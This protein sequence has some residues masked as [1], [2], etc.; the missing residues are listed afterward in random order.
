MEAQ[1]VSSVWVRREGRRKTFIGRGEIFDA[2]ER[3][4]FEGLRTGMLRPA[5]DADLELPG[6]NA[7]AVDHRATQ[8]DGTPLD[9]VTVGATTAAEVPPEP[10]GHKEADAQAAELGIQF[11]K[12]TTLPDKVQAIRQVR[13][14]QAAATDTP[15]APDAGTDVDLSTLPDGELI[16]LGIDHGHTEEE[17]VELS[18]DELVL[19]VAE[20]VN[21]RTAD[22]AEQTSNLTG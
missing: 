14:S 4:Y 1:V 19:F 5:S 22:P 15:P 7:G 9:G 3:E 21:R 12:K 10:T 2:T 20:A 18:H 11:P 13:E 6:P 16:Q 17:M 8:P